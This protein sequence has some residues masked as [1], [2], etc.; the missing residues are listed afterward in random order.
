MPYISH[1]AKPFILIEGVT[2]SSDPAL[3]L[4]QSDIFVPVVI[5]DRKKIRYEISR[6]KAICLFLEDMGN[7]IEP[8]RLYP[9]SLVLQSSHYLDKITIPRNQDN[10]IELF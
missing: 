6:N 4:S 2:D 8:D 5:F 9:A 10:I 3:Q 7:V 1:K